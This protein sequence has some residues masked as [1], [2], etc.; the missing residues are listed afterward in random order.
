MG[1]L[2]VSDL[3]LRDL[4]PI[5]AVA[6][7]LAAPF[8]LETMLG[9]VVSAARHVLRAERAS[10]WLYEAATDEL[11]LRFSGELAAVRVRAST[12]LVGTCARNRCLINVPDCYADAR[13][14][15]SLDRQTGYRTRCLLTLPLIGHQGGLVGVMQVLN[16]ISGPFVAEDEVLA[17]VLAAQCAVALERV[18]VT[19][20]LLEGERMR[21]ELEMARVVQRATLPVRMPSVPGYDVHGAFDPAALTGGDTFDLALVDQ[22]L[23]VVLADATGHGMGPA[24]SVSQMQAMLR[25]AFRL[26]ADLEAAFIQ[27]NNLLA[28]GLPED[29]FITAFIGLLDPVGH[30]LRFHSAGQGP[31]LLLRARTRDLER[32]RPTSFP[33]GAMSLTATE[34]APTVELEPGD[35]LVVLSDGYLE[36]RDADGQ[37]YG[38][39]RVAQVLREHHDRS[40]AELAGMLLRSVRAFARDAPQEDDMTVVLIKRERPSPT[41]FARRIDAVGAIFDFV[42]AEFARHGVDPSLRRPVELALEELFTNMVK[43]GRGGAE[44]QLSLVPIP[45]GVEATL[46]DEGVE[47]FDPTAVPE[48]DV[49]RPLSERQ[50]GGLGIHLV[51]RL[52]DSIDYEYRADRR[53]S[54]ITFRKTVHGPSASG[55]GTV[56]GGRDALDRSTR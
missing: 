42:G 41:H 50:P 4:E 25:M 6:I 51:K 3:P 11:V 14:D 13:F 15:P 32:Y 38:E 52:V 21:K 8:D 48:V 44:V 12:G 29:H 37:E 20:A 27:A 19:D 23:L 26:G 1:A 53:Q 34:A 9:E 49:R 22:G 16:K 39:E 28:E 17:T 10:V 7:K 45:D 5:L 33:L 54:R 31:I 55:A 18:R 2:P 47:P 30:R 43:Y 35:V 40:M 46:V 24:L 56:R 36:H